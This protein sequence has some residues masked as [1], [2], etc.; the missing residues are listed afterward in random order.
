ME[1]M[2]Y[3][4]MVRFWARS[5]DEKFK[6]LEQV[7]IQVKRADP[8]LMFRIPTRTTDRG[9]YLRSDEHP[10]WI[11]ILNESFYVINKEGEPGGRRD[12]A[13]Y[14]RFTV[15]DVFN[16][17]IRDWA[18]DVDKLGG[19]NPFEDVQCIVWVRRIIWTME[20]TESDSVDSLPDNPVHVDIEI[21]VYREPQEGWLILY[22]NSDPLETVVLSDSSLWPN[23]GAIEVFRD[24]LDDRLARLALRFDYQVVR[25]GLW[26]LIDQS[27]AQ[28][29][30]GRIGDVRIMS[31]VIMGRLLIQLERG[32]YSITF[33]GLEDE[34]PKL[35]FSGIHGTLPGVSRIVT[36]ASDWWSQMNERMRSK[37]LVDDPNVNMGI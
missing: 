5:V 15:R 29:M 2:P 35:R 37:T 18:M 33:I 25:S 7:L 1:Q 23:S 30:S 13:K 24:V 34:K 4:R 19:E 20:E 12:A 21:T 26:K 9:G 31:Y 36:D 8:N 27:T 3:L 28:G 16:R 32:G 17:P 22:F 14:P 10:Q 11:G 6:A